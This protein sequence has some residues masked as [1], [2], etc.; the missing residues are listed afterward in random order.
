MKA[1][2]THISA[3]MDRSGSMEAIR[4]DT[5]G[6][7]NTFVADQKAL[8]GEATISLTEFDDKIELTWDFLP[9]QDAPTYHLQPRGWTALLDAVGI[10]INRLGQ[11]LAAMDEVDRPEKVVLVI[12][13]D[14]EEN[15]S[16]EYGYGQIAEMIKTQTETYNW[17]FMFLGANQDAILT[18]GRLGI[19]AGKSM[20]YAAN[21]KGVASS[22]GSV[23][24]K[25]CAFRSAGADAV[26]DSFNV[27]DRSMAMGQDLI[28]SGAVVIPTANV[29][30]T[31]AVPTTVIINP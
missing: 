6:G 16:Q 19:S 30:G 10:T 23:S 24:S 1:G 22:Y 21:S 5:E 15:K 27:A 4:T 28:N 17:E 3:I 20:S 2:Y 13:T 14:G 31:A 18:G 7:F 8:P 11:K 25:L 26:L 29:P 12:V 9:L